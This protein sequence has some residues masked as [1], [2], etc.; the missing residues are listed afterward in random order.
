MLN[1]KNSNSQPVCT[2]FIQMVTGCS[3]S[4]IKVVQ[5]ELAKTGGTW[6][7]TPKKLRK[8]R[9]LKKQMIEEEVESDEEDPIEVT[10][11]VPCGNVQIPVVQSPD[12]VSMAI[13]HLLMS[14]TSSNG[15]VPET[16]ARSI[17]SKQDGDTMTISQSQYLGPA[18]MDL[19]AA[20][21]TNCIRQE[22]RGGAASQELCETVSQTRTAPLNLCVQPKFTA[23]A[24]TQHSNHSNNVMTVLEPQ[25]LLPVTDTDALQRE[26]VPSL[27]QSGSTNSVNALEA[28]AALAH[29]S[30]PMG[31]ESTT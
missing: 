5:G 1:T 15:T 30:H 25:S 10:Q 18:V 6:A 7:P 29:T 16:C 20:Q 24:T 13:R 21:A 8:R 22:H 17:W 2:H 3:L 31:Q 27:Y 4:I 26:H 12:S 11:S 23:P 28:L 14:D 9:R 19:F